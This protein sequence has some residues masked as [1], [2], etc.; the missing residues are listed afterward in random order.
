MSYE[1]TPLL[2][3]SVTLERARI[4]HDDVEKCEDDFSDYD[5]DE[6]EHQNENRK[7]SSMARR[8]S[9]KRKG[10]KRRV[11]AA[12][13]VRITKGR[14]AIRLAGY[15]GVQKLAPSQL[16]RY[17]SLARLKV[18]AKKFLGPA[19]SK[20]GRVGKR[21]KGRKGRKRKKGGKRRKR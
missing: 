4:F 9:K 16:V 3:Y 14:V 12:K 7:G 15:G 21:R 20:G 19:S 13:G 6:D 5:E 8:V 2:K 18:A 17:I 10:G 11:K 1:D